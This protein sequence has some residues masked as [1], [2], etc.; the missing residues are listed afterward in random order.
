MTTEQDL[1]GGLDCQELIG[2]RGFTEA[3]PAMLGFGVQKRLGYC[4]QGEKS[5]PEAKEV[6]DLEAVSSGKRGNEV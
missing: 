5:S 1:A 3:M 6:L 2:E 4:G